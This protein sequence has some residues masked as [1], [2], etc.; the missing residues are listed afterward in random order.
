MKK[1]LSLLLA[2][3]MIMAC[4][5][6]CTKDV[7]E[8]P[9][10]DEE[11]IETRIKTFLSA[12]N[13][14]DM[15]T[16][17][18]C[19]DAKTR[20]AFQAM[21][22]LLGGL[23]GSAAGFNIDLSDLFSL[24]IATASGD[25][26]EL[27]ISAINIID[28]KKAVATTTMTLTGAG[29]QTI[30]FVMVYENN[31]WYISDMTDKKV[32]DTINNSNQ[33]GTNVNVSEINSVYNGNATIKFKMNDK[34]YS[35]VIN[36][37]GEIIYYSETAYIDWTPVGN[38]AGFV[39]TYTGNDK[40]EYTLFNEDG[41]RTITVDGD[42]FDTIIGYGDG[43]ILVYKNTSTIALE[44]YSYGV[45]DCN[46][47]WIK[48]LTAGTQLPNPSSWG[49]EPFKHFGDGVFITYDYYGYN[50]H[51]I[52][53]NTNTNRSYSLDECIIESNKFLN[54]VI[55]ARVESTGW[56]DARLYS[57]Y[58]SCDNSVDLPNYFAL[59]ADGTFEELSEFTDSCGNLL[60]NTNDEYMHILDRTNNTDEVYNVFPSDMIA[61]VQFEE[62]FG[63]IL[64]NGADGKTYFTVIDK[65][66]NQKFEP[67]SCQKAAISNGRIVYQ[68]YDNTYEVVDT[69]GNIIVSKSQGYT[70]I[71]P[72]N[73]GIA[74]AENSNG[75][76]YIGVDGNILTI[77]LP[78]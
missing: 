71:D 1:I 34:S 51:Y 42:I 78:N 28:E 33:V 9:P 14:G 61:S 22:N 65:N 23:A 38:G 5:A 72:Y 48:P 60:I 69:N 45:L 56:D 49:W 58:G 44:E 20:N 74:V 6:S 77:K 64:L 27:E 16:V 75:Q 13:S 3:I 47:N 36:S 66:C 76:C 73:N 50:H 29:T 26:M 70:Y 62:D 10:T 46:G 25:F 37:K 7:E 53:Y 12:Y 68:N 41:Q 40:N 2:V 21:L 32:G 59:R 19:L 24:G 31:G 15:D 52:M 43:L 55:Y 39:T 18:E 35:G 4:F 30:Y 17:L 67:V 8:I 57:P 63:L 11:L 54:G